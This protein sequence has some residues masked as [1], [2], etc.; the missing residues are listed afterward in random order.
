[1]SVSFSN[2]GSEMLFEIWLMW[3]AFSDSDGE[4]N[5]VGDFGSRCDC[6]SFFSL[7][8]L[9]CSMMTSKDGGFGIPFPSLN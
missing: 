8:D 3:T 4:D 9:I 6:D 1:M 7:F 5:L 2:S